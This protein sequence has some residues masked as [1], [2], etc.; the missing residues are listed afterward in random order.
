M[1]T[2]IRH[3]T[4]RLL[5]YLCL[6]TL[7]STLYASSDSEGAMFRQVK[8][9]AERLA[10]PHVPRSGHSTFYINGELT[11]I[12]GHTSGFIPTPTAEYYKDGEWHLMQMVYAH[13]GGLTVPLKSGKVLI[14]GGFEKHLGIGQ[15]FVVEK[16]DPGDHSFTGFGCLDKKRVSA[17]GIE[18]DSSQVYIAGNWYHD[19]AIE[20]FDGVETFSFFKNVT[21]ERTLPHLLRIAP[22]D[23]LILGGSGIHGE[24]LHSGIVDRLHGD[25]LHVPLLE[26]WRPLQFDFGHHCDN[27]FIGNAEKGIFAYLIP[28][29]N[30]DGQVA[31]A[32]VE[33]TSFSLLPTACPIPTK[34][35][36]G[37]IRYYTPVVVDRQAK[38]GYMM[39]ID[40][41]CRQYILAI[42]YNKR[43]DK[44]VPLTL[45]YTDPL[46]DVCSLPVLTPDGDLVMVGGVNFQTNNNYSPS[47]SAYLFHVGTTS[48][49]AD[50]QQSWWLWVLL[51]VLAIMAVVLFV[52]MR[53]RRQQKVMPPPINPN[54]ILIQR[55]CLLM[56]NQRLFLNSELKV[57]DVAAALNTNQRNISGCVKSMRDCSFAQFVNNYRIDY[58]K[59]LLRTRPDIKLTEVYL[60]SGF[61]NETS[62]FRTFKAIT[63]Q[64]PKEWMT[65]TDSLKGVESLP[66]REEG[67]Y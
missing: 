25:T 67:A 40:K 33:G 59:Q 56:E 23:I 54:E 29:Q 46:P 45:Y 44:G 8:I 57:S 50:H 34:S 65:S 10:S 61:A 15:T 5:V 52:V 32:H 13:D 62:F 53:K 37:D 20:R 31:I 55:I 17:S 38:R 47:G 2:K 64:T 66:N 11:V 63:G 28:V 14:A 48:V 51:A 6:V 1:K 19:D 18:L 9:V 22:N 21:E 41:D 39:G 3:I 58:A 7:P 60:K 43:I 36:W 24:P 4:H 42:D 16:Y 26:T 35:Q 27:S 49:A 12:G 30:G